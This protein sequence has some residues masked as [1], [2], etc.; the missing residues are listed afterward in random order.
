MWR[1]AGH[2]LCVLAAHL[3]EVIFRAVNLGEWRER[4]QREKGE[5]RKDEAQNKM[6]ILEQKSPQPLLGCSFGARGD[7]GAVGARGKGVTEDGSIPQTAVR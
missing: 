2:R 5:G 6:L 1:T 3:L 4:S 7:G